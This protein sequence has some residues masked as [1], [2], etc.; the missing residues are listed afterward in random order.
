MNFIGMPIPGADCQMQ[1]FFD[2]AS[3]DWGKAIKRFPAAPLVN[4]SP[5]PVCD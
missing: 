1:G 2:D 5:I 4:P 3:K